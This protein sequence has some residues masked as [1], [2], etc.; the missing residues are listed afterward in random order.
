MR[1]GFG[2]GGGGGGGGVLAALDPLIEI[3][4]VHYIINYITVTKKS[5]LQLIK[6][7]MS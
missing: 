4:S 3:N 6:E 1:V 5:K 2:G 7:K